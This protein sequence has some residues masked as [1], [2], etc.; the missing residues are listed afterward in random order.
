MIKEKNYDIIK[1]DEKIISLEKKTFFDKVH[2]LIKGNKVI[3]DTIH[4]DLLNI[5]KTYL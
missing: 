1:L 5:F 2:T 4:L 3:V